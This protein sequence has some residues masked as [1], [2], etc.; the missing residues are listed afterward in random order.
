MSGGGVEKRAAR[1]AAP[2]ALKRTAVE[3]GREAAVTA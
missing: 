3:H 2:I 1:A